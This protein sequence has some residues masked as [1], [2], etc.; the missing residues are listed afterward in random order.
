MTIP[1]YQSVMLPLLRLAADGGEHSVREAIE[2][3]ADHF[4]LSEDE[5]RELLP[6]GGQA[7]F[8]NRVGWARTYMKKAGLLE[9]P[10]RGYF[11]ITDRGLGAL[12]T[13]PEAI[14]VK[15]LEQYP[16]FLEFK[17]RSNTKSTTPEIDTTVPTEERTPREV[18]EDAYVTIRSGLVSDLLEQ[19]MQGSPSFFER[20]VVDLLVQMGYG[21]TR[22]DAGEAVGGS[23]DEGI[24]GIIKEDRLGLEVVYIQAKRWSNIVGRPEIQRF[25]GALHGQNARKG[26]FITT[27]D[28]SSGA[29]EYAKGL[30]DKVVLIDGEM[31]ANLMI[32]HGVGVSLEEAY[33]IKRVDSDYFNEA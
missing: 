9:S 1:D 20:L 24:D 17:A 15:F 3:L 26:V 6:S 7:T 31:F 13:N 22:R 19:I 5:R 4:K 21:G 2:R 18:I 29:V 10:R 16:E 28:F 11:K 32:D 30:Q 23:G 33:E 8:D 12:K 27:S 25:V 14:N